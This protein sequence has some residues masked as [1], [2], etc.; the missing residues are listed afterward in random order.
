MLYIAIYLT[1]VPTITDKDVAQPS[2]V[3]HAG[4]GAIV[5]IYIS[6]FGW[7]LGWNSIQFI[8]GA[9]IFPIRV[10]A[11]ATS[12]IMSFHYATQYG[13]SKAV[14]LMLLDSALSPKGTFWLF[15]V[16]TLM[17]L[18][19]I[20]FFLPETAGKS[21]ESMDEMF[22]LPWYI[23]GRKGAALTARRGSVAEPHAVG[24]VEN[25]DLNSNASLREAGKNER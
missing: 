20:T 22:N 14:P 24:D 5:F 19:F 13:N 16:I 9:E 11:V 7:A 17:G 10:R 1:A 6:G 12:M 18:A 15:A 2:S 25:G 23:I 8:I 4:T 3:K 21:L